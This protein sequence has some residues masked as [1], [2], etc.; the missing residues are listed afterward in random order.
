MKMRRAGFGKA[1]CSPTISLVNPRTF[2]KHFFS[3]LQALVSSS[4]KQDLQRQSMSSSR[5]LGLLF[6][7]VKATDGTLSA[8][9][10]VCRAAERRCVH[11]NPFLEG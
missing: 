1:G 7:R 9:R 6:E 2:S 10:M 11:S 5:T 3:Y 8:R 4:E